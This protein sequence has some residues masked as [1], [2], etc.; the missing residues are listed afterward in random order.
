MRL[1]RALLCS[2]LPLLGCPAEQLGVHVPE[3]GPDAVSH[4]DLT[5]DAHAL[6]KLGDRRP[7]AAGARAGVEI[8]QRRLGEMKTL[9]AFGQSYV[10]QGAAGWAV[11]GQKDG[12]SDR[13]VLIVAED[14]GDGAGDSAA[15]T[16]ALISLAKS[17]DLNQPPPETLIFCA[18]SAQGGWDTLW[19]SPP[20]PQQS[21]KTLVVLGPLGEREGF[22][23]TE[24]TREAPGG[25]MK[26]VF[27]TT[28]A[29]ALH[30]GPED[31]MERLDYV[32]LT[33]DLLAVRAHIEAE[34]GAR[35]AD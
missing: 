29:L 21:V 16:A 32:G 4:E 35:A 17:Y 20:V 5:R 14:A 6:V 1:S 11:C 22:T 13:A 31:R 2:L 19:A 25:P 23:L 30:E 12:R 27:G 28:G 8:I 26:G 10:A 18:V 33:R 15:P 9:P 34:V 24:T 7:G 3:G